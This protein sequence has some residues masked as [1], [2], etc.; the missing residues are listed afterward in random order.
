MKT[1]GRQVATVFDNTT[2]IK[3][4]RGLQAKLCM[5][6][7]L[8]P[9][10]IPYTTA[11]DLPSS[12]TQQPSFTAT[13]AVHEGKQQHSGGM[14]HSPDEHQLLRLF[15][16]CWV[17]LNTC[18]IYLSFGPFSRDCTSATELLHTTVCWLLKHWLQPSS[19]K[20]VQSA[21]QV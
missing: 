12:D 14:Q 13:G 20:S 2:F 4:K 7:L 15:E 19:S 8:T 9:G 17:G 3:A 21:G 5:D 1:I 18:I 6:S 11:K 16:Q 10:L